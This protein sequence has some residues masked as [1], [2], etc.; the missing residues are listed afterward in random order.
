MASYRQHELFTFLNEHITK[1][2]KEASLTGMG[3]KTGRW[4]ITN[5][6][7]PKF[8]D[9][10]HDYLFIKNLSPLN[11][12]EQPRV[13]ESKPLMIYIDFNYYKSD[14]IVNIKQSSSISKHT[15]SYDSLLPSDVAHIVK[16][17]NRLL[18]MACI[19]CVLISH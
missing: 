18:K 19:L 9:L 12:V 14:K 13:N 10:L 7:Y 8:Y 11:L 6:D 4:L 5:E 1:N 17:I 16:G 15:T 2:S 3:E